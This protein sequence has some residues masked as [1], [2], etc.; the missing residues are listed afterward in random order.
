MFPA[1][2]TALL[3][4]KPQ[5]STAQTG[6]SGPQPG[7]DE[8]HFMPLAPATRKEIQTFDSENVPFWCCPKLPQHTALAFQTT[9]FGRR[10][11][12]DIYYWLR[13]RQVLE[14]R[15]CSCTG[16]SVSSEEVMALYDAHKAWVGAGKLKLRHSAQYY[17]EVQRLKTLVEQ[18]CGGRI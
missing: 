11:K 9:T 13:A 5:R 1:V 10:A 17:R 18:A 12:G 4:T 3:A 2:V 14:T 6:V 16:K 15:D 7:A 8:E